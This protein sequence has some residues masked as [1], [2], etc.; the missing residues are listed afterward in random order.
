MALE[1]A[2]L[3]DVPEDSGVIFDTGRPIRRAMFGVDMEAAEIIIAKQ[4]GYDA[5]ITHHPKGGHPMVNLYQV[6]ENQIGRM[7][8][9]GCAHQ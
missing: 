9:A 4:L 3:A 7:V 5:V 8:Q 2:G 1:A 6:M